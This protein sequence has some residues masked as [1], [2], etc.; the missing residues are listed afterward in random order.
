[1]FPRDGEYTRE[2]EPRALQVYTEVAEG[3][4]DGSKANGAVTCLLGKSVSAEGEAGAAPTR[5]GSQ[6][7][8]GG[9]TLLSLTLSGH[10]DSCDTCG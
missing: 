5:S 2:A 6:V 9:D 10:A 7:L 4:G 8:R 1:M 3:P